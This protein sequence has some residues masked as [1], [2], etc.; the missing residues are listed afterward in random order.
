[1]SAVSPPMVKYPR[2]R[3]IEGSK[4]QP[5][6]EDL[7]QVRMA[8]LRGLHLVV[9]E[10]LDGANAALSFDAAGKL[11]LQSRGHYLTGGA[12]EKHFA[13][14]KTWASTHQ[15]AMFATLGDRYVVFG[16]W[17]YAKHTVYYDALPHWFLEFDCYDRHDEVFLSTER[18]HALLASLPIRH[19]PVVHE[20]PGRTVQH[21]RE[22][23]TDSL[24]KTR[25]WR[26]HLRED[27]AA[28]DLDVARVVR[29]TDPED[30]SE[31]LYLKHERDGVVANRYKLIRPTFLQAVVT[32]D[33]HWLNRPIV[34]NRLAPD[35]DI[36]AP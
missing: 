12:R 32:A 27:A 13:L 29:Q 6:D 21:L 33:G 2:T 35:V 15:R 19:V 7:L 30:K 11:L 36:Y 23:I 34:P 31:G 3:H 28:A 9:E 8:S 4:L 18:R 16:E 17:L 22:L 26:E 14:F 20:G 24:Y 5:G 1:M 25:G 10:K